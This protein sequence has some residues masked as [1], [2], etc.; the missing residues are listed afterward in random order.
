MDETLAEQ[1]RLIIRPAV[2]QNKDA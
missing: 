2:L 1:K